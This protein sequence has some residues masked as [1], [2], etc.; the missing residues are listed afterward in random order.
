M[1]FELLLKKNKLF[2]LLISS[3]IW[4]LVLAVTSRDYPLEFPHFV[5]FT[6]LF[7]KVFISFSIVTIL[8]YRAS[9]NQ[10][11]FTNT[12]LFCFITIAFLNYFHLL[13]YQ[14]I[15]LFNKQSSL[16][17][18]AFF[19]LSSRVI[20]LMALTAI[21]FHLKLAGRKTLWVS[22]ALLCAAAIGYIGYFNPSNMLG[23]DKTVLDFHD[24]YSYL[25]PLFLV[26]NSLLAY[27]F[28]RHFQRTN[29]TRYLYFSCSCL[30]MVFF[31]LTL[32]MN[33]SSA[34]VLLVACLFEIAA[35][36]FIYLAIYRSEIQRSY[37]LA[38]VAGEKEEKINSELQAI[39]LNIPIGIARFDKAYNFLYINPYMQQMSKYISQALIGKNIKDASLNRISE[40]LI[41]YMEQAFLGE[42]VEFSYDYLDR[43]NH[44]IYRDVILVPEKNQLGET[45]TILFL[46]V[47]T[48]KKEHAEHKKNKAIIEAEK[49][50]KALDEHAIVA[51]T[52]AKGVITFVNQKFC[53]IS[54]YKKEELIGKTH[55]IINA[56]YHPPGFFADMWKT[57]A[58]GSI[59]HGEICNRAKDGSIYWV[60]TT[61]VPVF[62]NEGRISEYIAV[63][64]DVTQRKL[65][66]TAAK[67]LAYYDELTS[68]PNRRSLKDKLE[69]IF[70]EAKAEPILINAL[71]LID[72]DNFKDINDSLGH[73]AGDELLKKVGQRLQQHV[74][75]NFFAARLGGDEF[76]LLMTEVGQE[77]HTVSVRVAEKAEQIRKSLC[78]KYSIEGQTVNTTPSIG[79]ALFDGNEHSA[80]EFLKQADIA[81]YQSKKL[82][83]NLVSFFDPELQIELD[84][85]NVMQYEL[86]SAIKK[87]EFNLLYQPIFNE[88]Q[89]IIGCEAL[90][91][92]QN[93]KLGFVS[94]ALFIPQ[95]EQSNLILD[96]GH[97]VL[98]TACHQ[99]SVWALDSSRSHLTVAVNVSA[100]QLKQADF[101]ASVQKAIEQHGTNPNRL[102]LEI[103]ESMLQEDIEET[104]EAMRALKD[105]GI[106]FSLDDF[107]TGFSSLNYLTK[108]PI[109]TLKIDCSFVENM[110]NSEED[111]AVVEMILS[112]SSALKLDVVA[113]GVETQE[114]LDFLMSK[115]CESFQ[116]YLLAKPMPADAIGG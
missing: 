38:K 71:L 36:I 58:S 87:Q 67:R 43:H 20:E 85:R 16:Q 68:L 6:L 115:G 89:V 114:Q 108:L 15:P 78:E 3:L 82:G 116:G 105:I 62:D 22:I 4:L 113:E 110:I 45:Q 2:F 55:K 57:I 12:L 69:N 76:V 103:T 23:A 97:W 111:T 17:G 41:P 60:N 10:K 65:A 106:R 63:R 31:S 64:A 109:D 88:Q 29:E 112:L 28:F 56:S 46:A 59:W 32:I 40:V 34:V 52:N 14:Q 9:I 37:E 79:V 102:K 39:L 33:Q 83:R 80:S 25:E 95:A 72:L 74:A 7:L 90:I 8:F 51:F 104:I 53:D 50:R 11:S 54:Q 35:V 93:S 75:E 92:W 49:L 24:L 27:V 44:R 61:I 47:D 94:P 66:E 18:L 99:L 84:Q 26:V 101:V 42:N 81:M 98:H 91:R 5:L 100:R 86:M 77:K 48:S 1:G 19:K 21:A 30:T 107:G 96:I 73:V 70:Q 13:S